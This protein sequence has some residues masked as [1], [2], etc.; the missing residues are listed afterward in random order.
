[1]SYYIF[2]KLHVSGALCRIDCVKDLTFLFIRQHQLWNDA[3]LSS[4]LL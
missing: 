3:Y 1:M 4:R 2:N